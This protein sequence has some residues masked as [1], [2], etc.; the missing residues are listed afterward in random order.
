MSAHAAAARAPA[1]AA[2]PIP[3]A[4]RAAARSPASARRRFGNA[5]TAALLAGR[6]AVRLKLEVGAASDPLEREADATADKVVRMKAG[7]DCAACARGEACDGGGVTVRRASD[8][9]GGGAMPLA[10]AA[11]ASIRRAT[12]GGEAL[13]GHV[14]V[15]MEPAF[16]A[17]F[18]GVRVHRDAAAADSAR[19]IGARAYTVGNHIAFGTGQWA[20]GTDRG[21]HLIAHELTHTLQDGGGVLKRVPCRSAAQCAAP[22]AGD[23]GAF[24][25]AVTPVQSANTAAIAAAPAASPLGAQRALIG[26]PAPNIRSL[27]AANG[28]TLRS[29]VFG[30]FQSP[31]IEGNVGAQTVA[32][33]RFPNES[34]AGVA[35][36]ANPA[37]HNRSCIEVPP[38]MEVQAGTVLG[39]APP[40]TLS[41]RSARTYVLSRIAHEMAHAHFDSTQA[42]TITPTADCTLSTIV[43]NNPDYPSFDHYRVGFYLSEIAGISNHFPA[44]FDN[45]I[46]NDTHGDHRLLF[47]AERDQV[48][49]RYEGILGVIQ[50]LQCACSCASVNNLVTQTVNLATA[51]WTPRARLAFLRA[52][53]RIMPSYWPPALVRPDGPE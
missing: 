53:T 41:Q 24:V 36:R 45:F 9:G 49:N 44:Y 27:M 26:A 20:P 28:M 52:M 34:P 47:D 15:A 50:G 3:A 23:T 6:E 13:P 33:S 21:D 1:R 25:T 17:D 32:C 16:G 18:S 22:S 46:A 12:S 48:F 2:R 19:G 39:V 31:R 8:A 40:G 35:I 51:D 38:A 43:R 37:A 7:G 5:G 4:G 42:A 11:E 10:P 30:I 29:E 14:R